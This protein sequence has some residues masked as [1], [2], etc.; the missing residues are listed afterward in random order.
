MSHTKLYDL[1]VLEKIC[2]G[3]REFINKMISLFCELAPENVTQIKEA[4][5][6]KDYEKVSKTAHSIKPSL[7][8]MGISNLYNTI[9]ELEKVGKE[10]FDETTINYLIE[11]LD[12]T[13]LKIV[14]DL[15]NNTI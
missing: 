15:K 6:K 13:I 9:R 7:D 10:P 8:Q 2:S 12:F 1:S 4:W 11:E 5:Q 3:D 14:A